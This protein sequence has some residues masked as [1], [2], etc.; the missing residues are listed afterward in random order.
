MA[1]RRLAFN[2]PSTP[3]RGHQLSA[4]PQTDEKKLLKALSGSSRQLQ[5][6]T[7]DINERF[8]PLERSGLCGFV[9]MEERNRLKE[10]ETG[11][12]SHDSAACETYFETGRRSFRFR[13]NTH[14]A[15]A[16]KDS[17]RSR[18]RRKT[19]LES[20]QSVLADDEVELWKSATVE[21]TS[22]RGDALLAG[23]RVDRT[24]ATRTLGACTTDLPR[25]TR[26]Q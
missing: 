3:L 4:S 22:G 12:R 7:D 1:G 18:A 11:A 6:Q 14:E 13:R 21:L 10:E 23:S 25:K 26:R 20:R 9:S 17:A 19:L 15:E 24:V 2:S 8:A 16:A 5:Q